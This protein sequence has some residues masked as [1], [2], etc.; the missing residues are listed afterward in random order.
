MKQLDL[1]LLLASIGLLFLP[2]ASLAQP[3][4]NTPKPA[5]IVLV[6]P[7]DA[8]YGDYAC[9]GNPVMRTPSVDAFKKQSLLFTR[10][11]VSPTCSP[12]RAALMSG[13]HEFRAGVT[14]T[15][16][17]RERMA[18]D[19]HTLPQMLRSAGYTTGIFGKWHLGDEEPHRP[20]NRGFDEVYIHGS[21]GIGQSG[22]A[23]G[24]TNIDPA[25]WHNGRFVR[26]QG[27]CTDLFFAQASRWMKAR[28]EAGES[29][30][31]YIAPNAPHAPHVLP[32]A[33][34]AHYLGKPRVSE[35]RAKFFGMIE[36]IDTNFGKMLRDLDR[37]GI[38]D[39]TLVIYL[40]TDNGGTA[41]RNF[42]NAG[43]R[44]G[45][46]TSYQGGTRSPCFVRWPAGGVPANAECEALAAHVDLFPTLA[47]L[48]G[49]TVPAP[50]AR[51]LEGRSLVP[52]LNNPTSDWPERV[53]VHHA[54]RWPK[55][56]ANHFKYTKCAIQNAR[57]TLVNN[58]EL[59][60]LMTDPGETRNVIDDHPEMVEKLRAAY[61]TWWT[62]SQPLMVNENP[63]GFNHFTFRENYIKQ[64][65]KNAVPNPRPD[66]DNH[67][68]DKASPPS[69]EE[70]LRKR[71]ERRRK[72]A[73]NPAENPG[74]SRPNFVVFLADDMGWGDAATYGH[75]RIQT[76]HL[77][78]LAA[79][80][81]KF[82]Q[83]YSAAGVCSPSRAAILTGR[84]PYRNGV[85]RHLSG[86][87]EAH[88]RKSEITYPK[89]LQGIGY[90][91][92]HV[93]KWH[94]NARPQFNHPDY[95]QPGDHG[96]DHWVATHNNASPSHKNPDNFFRNGEPVG[97]TKSYSAQ[98]VAAEAG[99]WL[100][101]IRD[102]GKPFALSVWVH[103]PH[104]PIA[105]DPKFAALY[106]GH[107]NATYMG[108]ISQLDHALGQVMDALDAV[109]VASNTLVFF[110]SDNGPVARYGGTTGGLRG[111]KRS[112]HEGGIRVP[113]VV[114]WP[115][116]IPAGTTSDVPVIGTDIFATVLDIVGLPLPDD[117]T[118]DGVSMRPAF[119]GAPLE[120]PVPLFW[121]THV[122]QPGDR[123]AMRIGDWKIVGNDRLT[124]F[125]LF[126]IQKDWKEE[127]DLAAAMP[128]QL[129]DMKRTLLALWN[130]IEREGPRE[131]WHRNPSKSGALNY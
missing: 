56:Q 118:I 129:A 37:W 45:K 112:D 35:G 104:S 38:A 3:T 16:G 101:E 15:I 79:E 62:E 40:G 84:T 11:H 22:D 42:F 39:E 81:V 85:W 95:P 87:H 110:T 66:A 64:F 52:L 78:K 109:G 34:Y 21:G 117:R 89:M 6:M 18:L 75:P 50:T 130:E 61:E 76:P 96:Y 94:L 107:E 80:G 4:Q 83:C 71:K 33:A 128:D 105:T 19:I 54:G 122:S 126:E 55:G 57:F 13:R 48:A 25:L 103:E 90:E 68:K 49:A 116:H 86:N 53:L 63:E 58:R 17:G 20:E 46:N 73:E 59:Y 115:G 102:P 123:V 28:S 111:G 26:T 65:G 30:F 69:R 125:Q 77:D 72:A 121:R 31:A 119:T 100:K 131:W 60:D 43:L 114:R 7:D 67:S 82:T 14:H 93:G 24:N 106:D 44:G 1:T 108:N 47:D 9:L 98:F 70:R 2:A 92:C 124:E 97:A 29:F 120:R 10:F 127:R 27:Y 23:P 99:R 36:N 74:E 8:G 113:G 5:N 91:T 41:G 88:L 51:R 12:C 32:P